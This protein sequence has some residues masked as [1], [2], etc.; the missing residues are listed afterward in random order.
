M[1]IYVIGKHK[2]DRISQYIQG[3][4][5]ESNVIEIHE[6]GRTS[7]GTKNIK[8]LAC[9]SQHIAVVTQ[10]NELYTVGS[11]AFGQLGLSSTQNAFP[12]FTQVLFEAVYD[13]GR[14][15]TAKQKHENFHGENIKYLVCLARS[16]LLISDQAVWTCGGSNATLLR[17]ALIY[18]WN[19]YINQR[20]I[21]N[22][23]YGANICAI[24]FDDRCVIAFFHSNV[25]LGNELDVENVFESSS[26][27]IVSISCGTDHIA[28]LTLSGNAFVCGRNE[29]HQVS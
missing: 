12:L 18:L 13:V 26:D 24:V 11:N 5:V 17:T 22:V 16:T 4:Q 7:P 19:G 6:H 15:L 3:K 21:T 25:R 1:K 27:R 8:L 20:N 9:G 28:L 10:N 14:R 23:V 2:E 29:R